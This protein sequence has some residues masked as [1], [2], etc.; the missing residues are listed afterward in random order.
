MVIEAWDPVGS[1]INS[2]VYV[3]GTPM[4]IT[5]LTRIINKNL[6]SIC[7]PLEA[8]PLCLCGGKNKPRHCWLALPHVR[9]EGYALVSH[10]PDS[11]GR[12]PLK[13]TCLRGD[14]SAH[15][16]H[17]GI[18]GPGSCFWAPISPC[19][20]TG[21][22]HH[23]HLQLVPPIVPQHTFSPN[24]FPSLYCHASLVTASGHSSTCQ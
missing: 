14:C 23:T 7:S 3:L 20:H 17:P 18:P 9:A 4:G 16:D 6:I 19:L 13:C 1:P 21:W 24:P 22:H 12:P 8:R 10:W 2:L 11:H 15:R 5:D